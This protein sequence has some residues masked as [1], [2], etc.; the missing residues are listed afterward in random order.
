MTD[1][2]WHIK[3]RKLSELKY[4]DKNPRQI[5]K[6]NYERLK[7]RIIERGFHDVLKL[8]ENDVVLSGNQRLRALIELGVKETNCIIPDRVMTEEEKDKVGLESNINDGETDF[9]VLANNFDMDLLH[10]VGFT[11]NELQIE[12]A[13][14]RPMPK[15]PENSLL[16][17]LVDSKATVYRPI[18]KS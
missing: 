3:K 12:S 17:S 9:D 8:D 11:D 2:T 5:S 7:Q 14:S 18:I 4:W 13:E 10:D 1:L 6:E 16:F 15:A